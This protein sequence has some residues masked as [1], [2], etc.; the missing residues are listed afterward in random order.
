[1][2]HERYRSGSEV[3]GDRPC[4]RLARELLADGR[5]R[6]V[7]VYSNVVTVELERFASSD[8]L[9]EAISGLFTYYRPGVAVAEPAPAE[10]APA[11][12]APA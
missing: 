2:G 4:D 1:M 7:H 9:A 11:E 8:G 10:P 12:P 5:V 6:S 3:T